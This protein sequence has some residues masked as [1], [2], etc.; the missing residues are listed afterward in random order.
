[1]K[2]SKERFINY[3]KEHNLKWSRQREQLVEL[4]VSSAGH[5]TAD[6]FYHQAQKKYPDIGYATV[7]RTLRLLAS[8]GIASAARFGHKSARYENAEKARH[9]DHMVCT[10]CGMIIEFESP[11]IEKAQK[12]IA[13]QK[14][15]TMTHHKM[16]L[17]G[18]CA[19]CAQRRG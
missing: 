9:H 6:E 15:F 5:V 13:R 16:V 3:L 10:R 4:F 18:V 2:N 11:H 12:Q 8:S 14:G 19:E 17:Y 1:M 7:Y